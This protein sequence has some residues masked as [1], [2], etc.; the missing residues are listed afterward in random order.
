MSHDAARPYHL[1]LL[2]TV[3]LSFDSSTSFPERAN[4]ASALH[5]MVQV[6][7]VALGRVSSSSIMLVGLTVAECTQW[8]S[9]S[10][11]LSRLPLAL[12]PLANKVYI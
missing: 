10:V 2:P 7:V 6:K 11:V 12:A 9:E 3:P 5:A 1:L 4:A 8:V